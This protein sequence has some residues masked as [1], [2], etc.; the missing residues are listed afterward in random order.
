MWYTLLKH[1]YNQILKIVLLSTTVII[2]FFTH[3]NQQAVIV[4][5]AAFAPLQV[6]TKLKAC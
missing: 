1:G 2:L 4:T 6:I 5:V 3:T